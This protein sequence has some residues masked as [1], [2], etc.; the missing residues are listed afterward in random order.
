MNEAAVPIE[1][2]LF[3]K[4]QNHA[5][6]ECHGQRLIEWERQVAF[7]ATKK[8]KLLDQFSVLSDWRIDPNVLFEGSEVQ[9]HPLVAKCWHVVTDAWRR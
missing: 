9:E 4:G 7:G 6:D 8:R 1:R 5:F 3:V 2:V